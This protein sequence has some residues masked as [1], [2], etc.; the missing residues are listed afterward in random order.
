MTAHSQ[1]SE[2]SAPCRLGTPSAH[3]LDD[4]V[5]DERVLQDV[6]PGAGVEEDPCGAAESHTHSRNAAPALPIP[7]RTPRSAASHPRT[8]PHRAPSPRGAP[9]AAASRPAPWAWRRR[10]RP[11]PGC[12]HTC[13]RRGAQPGL[14]V[15][16]STAAGRAPT[17][18]ARAQRRS[19]CGAGGGAPGQAHSWCGKHTALTCWG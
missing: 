6:L 18:A 13:G 16:P 2:L 14:R 17:A 3:L 8:R 12:E 19:G 10:A 11:R 9:S 7:P 5:D 1:V 15:P 4:A